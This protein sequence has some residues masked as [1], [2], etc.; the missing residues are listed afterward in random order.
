MDLDHPICF[1]TWLNIP[2]LKCLMQRF[3][4]SATFFLRIR[5]PSIRIRWIR[6]TNPELFLNPLFRVEIFE[7]AMNPE[8]CGRYIR[9]F[10]FIRWRNKIERSSLPWKAEQDANFARFT[11]HALLPIFTRL[12]PDTCG[13]GNLWIRNKKLRIQKYPDTCG[14]GL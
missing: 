11:T 5:L 1:E 12:N 3:Y 2:S 8:S 13:R 6:H 10:F 14:R 7:Y 9:I 4:E